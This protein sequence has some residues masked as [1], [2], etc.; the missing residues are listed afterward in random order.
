MIF[1]IEVNDKTIKAEKGETILSALNR[2]GINVP[3]LCHMKGFAFTGACRL[4]VV[5]VEGKDKLITSCS[6]PVEEWMK[7]KTHSPR[8]IKA[9]QTIVELLLANHPD[10]CLY[11]VRN[12]NC[13][14]QTLAKQLNIADR[15]FQG[16][17]NQHNIDLSSPA[18][19]R[20]PSKCILC[21][22]CVRVCEEVISVSAIDFSGRGNQ[23]VIRTAYN[24][25]LNVSTCVACGQCIMVCPTGALYEKNYFFNI[26][27]ALNNPEKF[28][29]VQYAPSVSVSLAEE[30]GIKPGKDIYGL[31][32][33]ALR[34]IGFKRIFDTSFG[35]DLAI[36]ET[37]HELN[38][39]LEG[40]GVLPLFTSD[41][42]SW[43]K[44]VEEFYPEF[45]PHLSTCK[46]PQ[47][48]MGA[49]IKSFYCKTQGIR[50]EQVFSVSVMPCTAKKFEAQRDEM[51]HKGI[52]DIDAVMTTR[53]L[54]QFIRLHGIDL[55]SL[56]PEPADMPLGKRSSAGKLFA[57]SGGVA[58]GMMRTFLYQATGKNQELSKLLE[59]RGCR[60]RKEAFFKVQDKTIGVALICGLANVRALLEEIRNGRSDLHFIE[61]MTCQGGCISGGGQPIGSDEKDVKAR[62]KTIYEIDEKDNLK[63]A[64]ENPQIIELYQKFLETPGSEKSRQLLHT[65]FRKRIIG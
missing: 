40:D 36:M 43:V 65:N 5:E 1:D 11:C 37:A 58:E 42:P 53:E 34:K 14:L 18:L 22:R 57:I 25:G 50:P 15:R 52:S 16:R 55:N 33:A 41:C 30:F 13:E 60:K 12:L 38:E 47:Q 63:V 54:A 20:D 17:K 21:G 4:C 48:M 29:V 46:S 62:A 2:A 9:R 56:E 10:D 59:L 31:L 7:I 8:V 44:F 24:K 28:V 61:V 64:H 26:T 45:I 27:E 19:V 23:T 6:F 51:A 35:A 3:T 39:R 49:V 32:N